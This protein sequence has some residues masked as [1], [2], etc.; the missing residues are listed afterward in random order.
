MWLIT[1]TKLLFLIAVFSRESAFMLYWLSAYQSDADFGEDYPQNRWQELFCK[2]LIFLS[3]IC[4]LY[5]LGRFVYQIL[6][7]LNMI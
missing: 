2:I 3:I 6:T 1:L 7:D 5:S 4:L